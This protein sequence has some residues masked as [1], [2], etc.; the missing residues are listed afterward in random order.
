MIRPRQ[1][2]TF[3]ENNNGNKYVYIR[4]FCPISGDQFVH[5]AVLNENLEV[6]FEHA[7]FARPAVESSISK[8]VREDFNLDLPEEGFKIW[9]REHV[10][11]SA[12]YYSV[13]IA[14]V[15]L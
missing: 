11:G 15:V 2:W 8:L 6:V 13:S 7:P 9:R 5:V 12:G 14:D 10:N 3:K 1:V 4:G